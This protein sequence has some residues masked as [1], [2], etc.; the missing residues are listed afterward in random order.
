MKQKKAAFLI[1]MLLFTGSLAGCTLS[2]PS[3]TSGNQNTQTTSRNTQAASLYDIA[4]EYEDPFAPKRKD[5][6]FTQIENIRYENLDKFKESIVKIETLSGQNGTFEEIKQLYTWL[7]QE[8]IQIDTA[9]SIS[10]LQYHLDMSSDELAEK[11]LHNQTVRAEANVLYEEAMR[12]VL[13]SQYTQEFTEFI[14]EDVAQQFEGDPPLDAQK[15]AALMVQE[16]ALVKEYESSL[17]QDNFTVEYNGKTWDLDTLIAEQDEITEEDYSAIA[18]AISAKAGRIK[19]E[20]YLQLVEIR[21]EIAQLNGYGNAVDYYYEKIYGRDYSMQ[22]AKEFHDDVKEYVVPVYFQI[23]EKTGNADS[24]VAQ[25]DI[26]SAIGD[27]LSQ[28]S[29]EMADLLNYMVEHEMYA[30]AAV[31]TQESFDGGETM[32]LSGYGQPYVYNSVYGGYTDITSTVHEFG[33][34]CDMYLN[35]IYGAVVPQAKYDVAEISAIGLELLFYEYFDQLFEGEGSDEKINLLTATLS[36]VVTGCIDDEFQQ[37]VYSYEG[38]LTVEKINELYNKTAEG[39]GVG[40]PGDYSWVDTQ[41][42]FNAPFYYIS[43]GVASTAALE[44]WMTGENEGYDK[45]KQM[46]LEI[47]SRGC[48][49]YDY[50]EILEACGMRGFKDEALLSEMGETLIREVAELDA[51]E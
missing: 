43:Y 50:F 1:S 24:V 39:Y 17:M 25:E 8:Y 28:I 12:A 38:E 42:N 22:E 10:R 9:A 46:Y 11:S 29:V 26:L 44:I 33:H 35:G 32:I 30:L 19:A 16:E 49:E 20:I 23:M 13:N 14:G 3:Q 37:R 51:E 41:H 6:H 4:V 34:Y 47:L 21:K 48:F 27:C 31:K 7:Y 40:R 2:E 18:K 36:N 5:I 45:A 15:L